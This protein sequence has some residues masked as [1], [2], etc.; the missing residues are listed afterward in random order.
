ISCPHIHA[1]DVLAVGCGEIDRVAID[2]FA[3][4]CPFVDLVGSGLQLFLRCE[5]AQQASELAD[6]RSVD[7]V[8]RRVLLSCLGKQLGASEACRKIIALDDLGPGFLFSFADLDAA[9]SFAADRSK[10]LRVAAPMSHE[11]ANGFRHVTKLHGPA[12]DDQQLWVLPP[13]SYPTRQALDL[14]HLLLVDGSKTAACSVSEPLSLEQRSLFFIQRRNAVAKRAVLE[15]LSLDWN[16][17]A[18]DP[19]HQF[20]PV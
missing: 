13:L 2:V 16:A 7:L 11:S 1:F 9:G 14:V 5:L 6:L 8:R 20:V 3:G 12:G 15:L 17:V 19:T 4:V 10:D 18:N